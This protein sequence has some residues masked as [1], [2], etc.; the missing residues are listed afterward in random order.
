MSQTDD[1]SVV[2]RLDGRP[3]WN[4][5]L[6]RR[7]EQHLGFTTMSLGADEGLKDVLTLETTVQ[8]E[9]L[10]IALVIVVVKGRRY[11]SDVVQTSRDNGHVRLHCGAF[12]SYIPTSPLPF[13]S[14]DGVYLMIRTNWR[15]IPQASPLQESPTPLLLPSQ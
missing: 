5:A 13:L 7:V 11:I 15:K 8:A 6:L 3:N 2:C 14:N 1:T 9:S 12:V 10:G 4:S